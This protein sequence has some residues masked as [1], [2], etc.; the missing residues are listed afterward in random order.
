MS[1]LC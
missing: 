1:H